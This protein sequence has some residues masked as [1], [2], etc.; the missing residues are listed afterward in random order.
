MTAEGPWS[1]SSKVLGTD[2]PFFF[3]EGSSPS[4]PS[5]PTPNQARLID[6]HLPSVLKQV[7]DDDDETKYYSVVVVVLL[8]Q[9]HTHTHTHSADT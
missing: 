4:H 8:A 2:D 5:H 9:T 6:T 7:R 1:P 3:L